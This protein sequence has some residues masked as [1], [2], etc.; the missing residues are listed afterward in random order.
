MT[1]LTTVVGIPTRARLVLAR[2]ESTR[3]VRYETEYRREVTTSDVVFRLVNES[4]RCPTSVSFTILLCFP[5]H[6]PDPLSISYFLSSIRYPIP[7]AETGK[8]LVIPLGSRVYE[9]RHWKLNDSSPSPVPLSPSEA[10]DFVPSEGNF[11]K[12]ER[13]GR[14]KFELFE[15]EREDCSALEYI[16]PLLVRSGPRGADAPPGPALPKGHPERLHLKGPR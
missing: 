9:W 2:N 14:A 12:E 13:R 4:E 16:L 15:S 3:P 1:L 6:H 8:S 10:G 7:T 5:L 11:L